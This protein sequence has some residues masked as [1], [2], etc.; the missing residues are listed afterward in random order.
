MATK[1]QI[2]V[3]LKK[4]SAKQ[5][6]ITADAQKRL[7]TVKAKATVTKLSKYQSKA[8]PKTKSTSTSIVLSPRYQQT[9]DK[10]E[11][12][13]SEF[14]KF[15]KLI[16]G[17]LNR[18][19]K[20]VKNL[21]E[22]Y[23]NKI[24]EGLGEAYKVYQAVISSPYANDLLNNVRWAL[25]DEGHKIQK[26]TNNAAM[27]IKYCWADAELTNRKV[28][29]YSTALQAAQLN[30]IETDYFVE[31]VKKISI[32]QVI[33]DYKQKDEDSLDERMRRARLI[34]LRWLETRERN[35]LAKITK[36][37]W[38]AEQLISAG[39]NQVVMLGTVLRRYDRE[40]FY[41]DIHITTILPPNIDIDVMVVDRMAKQIVDV[42]GE[43]EE[44]I[45]K[46]SEQAW[47][48]DLE[49]YLSTEEAEATRQTVEKWRSKRTKNG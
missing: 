37:A 10:L 13:D 1:K 35:S 18:I 33:A 9:Y 28:Y 20:G 27:I 12:K 16:A 7:A 3:P 6:K 25:I 39:T 26:N 4:P 32:T 21:E 38:S 48:D 40:S 14:S 29:D 42:V 17:E 11:M 49:A 41:A 44:K 34:I 23:R 46:I 15:E 45:N 19:R 8:I 31:W 47:G 30:N 36:T 2:K 5:A 43:Y 22:Q 24:Y